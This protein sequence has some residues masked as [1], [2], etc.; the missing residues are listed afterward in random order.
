MMIRLGPR[1]RRLSGLSTLDEH[2]VMLVVPGACCWVLAVTRADPSPTKA[3]GRANEQ[4]LATSG[5]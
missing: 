2:L 5:L 1:F 3:S 4:N